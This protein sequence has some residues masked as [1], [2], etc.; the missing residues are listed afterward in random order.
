VEL[1]KEM[2]IRTFD[3]GAATRGLC[4]VGS[5]GNLS[6]R[7][8][9]SITFFN[10][11]CD[12]VVDAMEQVWELEPQELLAKTIAQIIHQLRPP[13]PSFSRGA[14]NL[15]LS[16]AGK[17][18]FSECLAS[19]LPRLN[20]LRDTNEDCIAEWKRFLHFCG[21]H[22]LTPDGIKFLKRFE[23]KQKVRNLIPFLNR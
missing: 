21:K 16:P 4:D 20:R 10:L 11:P 22:E 13:G 14:A 2:V 7:S 23:F 5:Y 1:A 15:D 12:M 3:F 17:K 8:C 19:Q 6:G 18:K 9:H